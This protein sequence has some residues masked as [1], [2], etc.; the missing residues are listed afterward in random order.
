MPSFLGRLLKRKKALAQTPTESDT[1]CVLA[2]RAAGE[3]D[4]SSAIQLYDQAIALNPSHAEAY[5]K[6]GN[7]LK[8]IGRPREAIESYDKAIERRPDFAFAYCNRGVVQQSLGLAAEALAS[9]DLAI[10]IDATDAMAHYNR[11]LLMQ[12][13]HRWEEALAAYERAIS[14]NPQYAEAQFNRSLALMFLGDFERGW[15]AFEWRWKS[16]QRLSI[17]EERSFGQP[18]WLGKESIAGKRLLL[19]CEG[20][21]GDT[22]Q[23]C[24]YATLVAARGALVI[25]E[26]PP[27]LT[28]LLSSLEGASCV[29]ARGDPLPP[30]DYH[31][32]LMSMPLALKT[33]LDSIPAVP[34]YVSSNE[35][36]RVGWRQRLGTRTRPRVGLAW[37]GNPNNP[38]DPSRTISLAD[39]IGY[40]PLDLD[41]VCLQKEFQS[42]DR[43]TLRSN[44]WISLYEDELHDF[45]DTA[46]LCDCLDLIVTVDTSVA[47]LGGALGRPTWILLPFTP[48]WRWLRGRNDSPWYPTVK[49]Y[50][51][52]AVGIWKDVF[53]R[54]AADLREQFPAA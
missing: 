46:A 2:A 6:R 34:R 38:I 30:F 33:T 5:Y 44:P 20:G 49:L 4:F 7:A 11:A 31:C 24:R 3:Q 1:L 48:D 47:H 36:D 50:R 45:R 14:I 9:Y 26:T 17:G 43:E 35:S 23:F 15:Q 37:S 21:F 8:N 32:P 19:H 13:N 53:V 29:I 41:Y 39:W 25:L 42:A 40:L 52:S 10:S 18:V 12:E 28:R 54:L 51:Q 22:L 16:A 27:P